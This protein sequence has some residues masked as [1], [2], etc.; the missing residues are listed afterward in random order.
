MV[1]KFYQ[2]TCFERCKGGKEVS[3]STYHRHGPIRTREREQL[4]HNQLA[5]T[6]SHSHG[7]VSIVGGDESDDDNSDSEDLEEEEEDGEEGDSND[8]MEIES[9]GSSMGLEPDNLPLEV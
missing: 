8:G 4:E 5:A 6:G 2:C 1:K 7:S 3:R 9:D